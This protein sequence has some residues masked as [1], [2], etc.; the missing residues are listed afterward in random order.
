M[1]TAQGIVFYRMGKGSEAVLCH[2]SLGLGRFLFHRV[3]PRLAHDYTVVTWDPRGVGD[4]QHRDISLDLWV[5]D[6]EDI[7]DR[8][9]MPVHLFGVSLGCW[10]MSRVAARAGPQRVRSLVL[11][12]LTRGF[13]DGTQEVARRRALFNQISMAEF[14]RSYA[15][16]TL[17]PYVDELTRDNLVWQ[18]AHVDR[19]RYLKAMAAIYPVSNVDVLRQIKVP[20]LA[21]VGTMDQRTPPYEA[22][23]ARQLIRGGQLKVLARAGHLAVL[24]QP[25]RV[26]EVV[27]GFLAT[28]AVVD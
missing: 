22:D 17:T 1:E 21:V 7:M 11:A 2:P 25:Q 10:V 4:N 23:R 18:L 26:A 9:R 28:G 19:E 3:M 13:A 12:G 16:T 24:D 6:V 8:I 15:D 5:R 20:S 14:A 27:T